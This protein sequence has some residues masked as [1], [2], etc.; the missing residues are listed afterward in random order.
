MARGRAGPRRQIPGRRPRELVHEI[1]PGRIRLVSV[2][3]RVLKPACAR[4]GLCKAERA[5]RARKPVGRAGHLLPPLAAAGRRRPHSVRS[6]GIVGAAFLA[7][8][9]GGDR[10]PLREGQ[11]DTGEIRSGVDLRAFRDRGRVGDAHQQDEGAGQPGTGAQRRVSGADAFGVDDVRQAGE[12]FGAVPGQPDL[13]RGAEDEDAVVRI[14]LPQHVDGPDRG[15]GASEATPAPRASTA[16][17]SA[18]GVAATRPE[19]EI[20]P[21]LRSRRSATCC[22]RRSKR[23]TARLRYPTCSR[24]MVCGA[25]VA[26]V[27]KHHERPCA[28]SSGSSG[29][30]CF[31][32]SSSPEPWSEAALRPLAPRQ[33]PNRPRPHAAEGDPHRHLARRRRGAAQ[34]GPEIISV[35]GRAPSS[36]RLP[37]PS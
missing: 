20:A 6:R 31:S 34:H 25:T 29:R 15:L 5:A 14:L 12:E 8:V 23:S 30:S 32:S 11:R 33:R 35:A 4:A 10:E 2:D 9:A 28:R 1:A 22:S 36:S 7:R 16:R 19:T 18:S 37:V 13:G 26:N 17:T 21:N 3:Q 27:A 24:G